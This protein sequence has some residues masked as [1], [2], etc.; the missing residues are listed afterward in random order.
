M[1]FELKTSSK[2]ILN[3]K[4]TPNVKGYDAEEVDAFLDEVNASIIGVENFITQELPI[5]LKAHQKLTES[6]TKI[7]S[8]EIE[9]ANF[10]KILI[11]LD[12][13][14]SATTNIKNLELITRIA[15]LEKTIYKMGGDPEKIK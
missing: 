6:Q 11:D 1:A 9:I 4:F 14:Q 2:I 12:H 13:N 5:L 8:L 7:E 10:K 3:K 15:V